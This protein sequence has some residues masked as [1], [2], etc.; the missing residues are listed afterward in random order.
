MS[1]ETT[2][3]GKSEDDLIKGEGNA[4][5]VGNL[6]VRTSRLDVLLKLSAFKPARAANVVQAFADKLLGIAQ[7]MRLCA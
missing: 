6:V 1:V 3:P 7:P 2:L 5:S 4:S